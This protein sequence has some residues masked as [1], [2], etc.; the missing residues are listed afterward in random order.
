MRSI[1]GVLSSGRAVSS[2]SALNGQSSIAVQTM[3]EAAKE[4]FETIEESIS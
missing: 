1:L 2:L 3:A 4:L